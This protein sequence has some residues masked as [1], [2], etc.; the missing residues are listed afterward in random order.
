[1]SSLVIS[2]LHTSKILKNNPLKDPY[3]RE[4]LIYFPPSYRRSNKRYPVTYL[5]SGFTGFGKMNM[6]L[7]A[8]SENIQQRLDRL[9]KTKKIN[10]MI[11]VMP[12][13]FTKYG[14]SQYVNSTATGRYEDYLVKE[15]V[16]YVDRTFRTI[17]KAGARSIIG[18]SSGGYGA[19]WLGMKHP[20]IFGLMVT[21][22]GDSAFEYCYMKDFPDFVVQIQRYGKGHNALKNFIKSQIGYN[23]PKP[24]D[25]HNILNI[26]GMSSCYSPNP[27]RKEYNF[28]LP[29]DI[30]TGELIP[31]IWKK[32]LRFDPVRLVDKYKN[33]LKKLRLI[34]VDCGTSDEFNLQSGA[35]I[36][37]EKLRKRG[38]KCF[39]QEFNDGHM[40]IQYRYD[41]SFKY[42]S[43]YFLYK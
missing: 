17:P 20:D 22:S 36:F 8:Y 12:D 6:N 35:R 27:K 34:F 23:Q 16:P 24:K 42:I 4:L 5:I 7:S 30:Y 15:I 31:Q 11:V 1:M 37:V 40:N 43:D 26:I 19:M 14:G 32:W 29:F 33:N 3:Q 9:I 10:E 2:V 41:T 21:H 13:C 18:K 25:F 39:H 38:I 28:D